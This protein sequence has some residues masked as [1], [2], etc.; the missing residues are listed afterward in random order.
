MF[1]NSFKSQSYIANPQFSP[2]GVELLN[3]RMIP[4]K[5][6]LAKGFPN[7]SDECCGSKE[8]LDPIKGSTGSHSKSNHVV[9]S[10]PIRVKPL[11][12]PWFPNGTASNL[13]I[14]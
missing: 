8:A 13:S 12:T 4:Y 2:S 5:G 9:I 11:L 1:S 7:R 14:L 6:L 10:D 3:T